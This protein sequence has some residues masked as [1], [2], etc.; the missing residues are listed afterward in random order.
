MPPP[1]LLEPGPDEAVLALPAVFVNQGVED[2]LAQTGDLLAVRTGFVGRRRPL[3]R[4]RD[5]EVVVADQ[6]FQSQ[7]PVTGV[8]ALQG[9]QAELAHRQ[10][11]VVELLDVEAGPGRHRA[12][13]QARQH[14]EVAARGERELNAGARAEQL[15]RLGH[16]A[17]TP[18]RESAMVKT[19][20]RPVISKILTMRGSAITR[21]RSPPSSRQRLRAPTST[22]SAVESRKVT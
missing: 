22:P 2:L 10:P 3:E 1:A 6:Q 20:V 18:W 11:E 14:N 12:G 21:W 16:Q 13:H 15:G 8:A 5:V 17:P 19:L 7:V 9:E 4:A